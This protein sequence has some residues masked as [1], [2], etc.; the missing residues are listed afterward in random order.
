M[1]GS[2]E[3]LRRRI[4]VRN[5]AP[6]MLLVIGVPGTDPIAKRIGGTAGVIT[7]PASPASTTGN[8]GDIL[9]GDARRD[10]RADRGRVLYAPGHAP[11]DTVTASPTTRPT[12]KQACVEAKA[13]R[14]K[15]RNSAPIS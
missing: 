6:M 7:I 15:S 8:R 11:R 9:P 3:R 10:A 5:L 4:P 2:I 1:V 13:V 14:G 12:R